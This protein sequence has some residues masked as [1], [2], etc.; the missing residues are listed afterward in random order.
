MVKRGGFL[1]WIAY[2][3]GFCIYCSTFWISVI[4]YFW[5]YGFRFSPEIL[6]PIAIS[7]IIIDMYCKYVLGDIYRKRRDLIKNNEEVS[8]IHK[9][10]EQIGATEK[11]LEDQLK[12][13]ISVSPTTPEV[14]LYNKGQEVVP[15]REGVYPTKFSD[16]VDKAI[17]NAVSGRDLSPVNYI[18]VGSM[19]ILDRD[20]G[21]GYS[22][23]INKAAKIEREN[24]GAGI[25]AV[26]VETL[27]ELAESTDF[28]EHMNKIKQ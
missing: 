19:L 26:S 12:I 21:G 24:R 11:A 13:R 27:K 6:V 15:K 10:I 22:S 17:N 8:S 5:V 3:L 23:F 7:H 14:Q 16:F 4:L 20:L 2:P 28:N 1:K 9:L 18:E 25:T